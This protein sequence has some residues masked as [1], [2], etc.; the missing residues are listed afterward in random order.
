MSKKPVRLVTANEKALNAIQ[1]SMLRLLDQT[2][3]KVLSGE[4][5]GLV[6]VGRYKDGAAGHCGSAAMSTI[7]EVGELFHYMTMRCIDLRAHEKDG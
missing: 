6:M 5:I 2:R 4:L 7:E 1:E 3:E